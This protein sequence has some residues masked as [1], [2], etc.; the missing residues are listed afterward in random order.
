MDA[1]NVILPGSFRPVPKLAVVIDVSGSMVKEKVRAAMRETHGILERL[2]IPEFTAYAWNTKLV[3]TQFVRSN[4]DIEQVFRNVGGGTDMEGAIEYARSQGA[5]VVVCLTDC[6]C[7]WH[8]LEDRNSTPLVIGAIEYHHSAG[9]P[10][11][12]YARVVDITEG[13]SQ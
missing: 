10:L 1:E 12:S 11:P 5:E 7:S 9:Y 13:V 6:Q 2:A 4:A 8:R 3:A